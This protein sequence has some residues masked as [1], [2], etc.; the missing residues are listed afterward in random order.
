MAVVFTGFDSSDDE[1]PA[2]E[3]AAEEAAAEE[4]AAEEAAAEST[5]AGSTAAGS[6]A[7]GSTAAER[8]P[9][10][11]KCVTQFCSTGSCDFDTIVCAFEVIRIAMNLKFPGLVNVAC[12]FLSRK[13]ALQRAD[14]DLLL[15]IFNLLII[16][17]RPYNHVLEALLLC[18]SPRN[19]NVAK[20]RVEALTRLLAELPQDALC[21]QKPVKKRETQRILLVMWAKARGF[22]GP[23]LIDLLV[24]CASNFN[25]TFNSVLLPY[26]AF[27]FESMSVD[28]AFCFFSLD[29]LVQL[30]ERDDV[31]S[32]DEGALLIAL[33]PWMACH[34]ANEVVR[35]LENVE[36]HKVPVRTLKE[37]L[38]FGG[39]LHAFRNDSA[40]TCL[41]LENFR[42]LSTKRR[43]ESDDCDD[44]PPSEYFCPI[45]YEL[46]TDPVVCA[47]GHTYERAAIDRWLTKKSRSPMEN[48]ELKDTN[49]VA[50]HNL[51]ILINNYRKRCAANT[52]RKK[53]QA[54]IIVEMLMQTECEKK[55]PTAY[56]A[57]PAVSAYAGDTAKKPIC[58]D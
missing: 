4:A 21:N 44:G 42:T 6:T 23:T 36:L 17:G 27:H 35:V 53:Q 47:D 13:D 57:V 14:A 51:R 32:R 43:I 55:G 5:A 58:I 52:Q 18:T 7:A 31:K 11:F 50:N 28:P 20:L 22:Q 46:M 39:V 8:S 19:L 38:A 25:Q 56:N 16:T 24:F 34:P 15:R 12:V 30:L 49:L 3:A 45:T 37:S 54:E 26:A 9:M 40:I 2:E 29:F 33:G 1:Q 41:L 48:S 10:A